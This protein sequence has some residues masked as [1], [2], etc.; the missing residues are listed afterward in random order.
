M[1]LGGAGGRDYERYTKMF[2]G[3]GYITYL[4]CGNGF[5]DLYV[6]QNLLHCTLQICA[7]Y[8]MSILL[9]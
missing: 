2:E 8:C 9:P 1:G 6:C 4:D 5:M 7:V 3:D